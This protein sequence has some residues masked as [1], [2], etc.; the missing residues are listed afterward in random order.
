MWTCGFGKLGI[1]P[2]TFRLADSSQ[3]PTAP[4]AGCTLMWTC[5]GFLLFEL[6]RPF[7]CPQKDKTQRRRGKQSTWTFSLFSRGQC[8]QMVSQKQMP[9]S[10]FWGFSTFL[11]VSCV[12]LNWW[13]D[14][15]HV[16]LSHYICMYYMSLFSKTLI[17]SNSVEHRIKVTNYRVRAQFSHGFICL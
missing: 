13:L 14:A 3:V 9:N 6:I 16:H 12:N 7:T 8:S 1:V 10:P 4:S 5:R 11:S 17:H 2:T 15:A